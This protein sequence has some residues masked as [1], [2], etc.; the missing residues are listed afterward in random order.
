MTL[1]E[2]A[3]KSVGQAERQGSSLERG[4]CVAINWA[5]G[6]V[7]VNIGGGE[8]VMPMMWAGPAVSDQV[9][10]AN[11]GGQPVCLGPL[12]KAAVGT[13][14]S[15]PA[16]GKVT[17]KGDDG[18]ISTL[19]YND[20][21]TFA[22][23]QRVAIDWDSQSVAYKLA[24]DAPVVVPVVPEPVAPGPQRQTREFAPNGS[25]SFYGQSGTWTKDDVWCSDTLIG[26][27]FY[28]GIADTI[29]DTARIDAVQLAVT[30]TQNSYPS[31]LA[32]F[33]TH[34]LTGRNGSPAVSGAV[35]VSRG[36]GTK[37]LPTSFG[38]ALKTG[39]ARGIGTNHGG[40][41]RFATASAGSGRLFITY[42]V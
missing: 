9:W 16:N 8:R 28:D 1:G 22:A 20:A 7:T 19:P 39:A 29:P 41:H 5:T 36:S 17:V 10:V 13:V 26:C 31:S 12:P 11:L 40:L 33:G 15:A 25:G 32:T 4:T 35:A 27:Y 14:Q 3:G 6:F 18:L 34:T 23:Q 24:S 37:D 30:E 38:D 42:T 21:V 2:T